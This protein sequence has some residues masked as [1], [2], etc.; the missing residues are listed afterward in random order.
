[1]TWTRPEL[2]KKS[3]YWIDRNRY[4][5]LKYFCLQ[6]PYWCK[7]Y[8]AIDEIITKP[9]EPVCVRVNSPGD[10]TG[11]IVEMRSLYFDKMSLVKKAAIE[12][13]FDLAEYILIAVTEGLSYE[14]L[15][16]RFEIPCGREM[17]YNRYR[18]FFWV[19][20]KLNR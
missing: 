15:K 17:Y 6:Y 5:E 18:K 4:Y 13:D 9:F 7:C 12:T 8:H 20:D 14:K 19:L 3:K 10:P 16:A 2:S 1:M 11:K